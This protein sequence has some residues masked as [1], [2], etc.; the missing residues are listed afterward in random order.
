MQGAT[1]FFVRQFYDLDQYSINEKKENVLWLVGEQPT[2]II[3]DKANKGYY[4]NFMTINGLVQKV[5][6]LNDTWNISNI[7][8]NP[9]VSV[10]L[11]VKRINGTNEEFLDQTLS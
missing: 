3:K 8:S 11:L 5:E 9:N 1:E 4:S 7:D 2:K 10:S 6:I